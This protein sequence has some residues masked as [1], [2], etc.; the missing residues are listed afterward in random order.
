LTSAHW[1][2]FPQENVFEKLVAAECFRGDF[3]LI[4]AGFVDAAAYLIEVCQGTEGIG[5]ERRCQ[6]Y[7]HS[8]VDAS[9]PVMMRSSGWTKPTPLTYVAEE[10]EL[11]FYLFLADRDHTVRRSR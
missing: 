10:A 11:G 4:L 8:A 5:Q 9:A 2:K 7:C 1:K 3:S 6:N